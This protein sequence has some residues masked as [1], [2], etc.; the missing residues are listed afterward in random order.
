[1]ETGANIALC[2]RCGAENPARA[3][4]CSRCW[5]LLHGPTCP[6]C[7][8]RATR[9]GARFCEHCGLDLFTESSSAA[10]VAQASVP[11]TTVPSTLIRQEVQSP[12]TDS[13]LL[14]EP[15][16][17]AEVLEAAS[18]G[19][20]HVESPEASLV[21]PLQPSVEIEVPVHQAPGPVHAGPPPALASRPPVAAPPVA[22]PPVAAP[23]AA[24]PTTEEQPVAAP[25]PPAHAIDPD[26]FVIM[27]DPSADLVLRPRIWPRV[28]AGVAALVVA[29]AIFSA[30]RR[31]DTEG[32]K[33]AAVP[34]P[35]PT[36]TNVEQPAAASPQPPAG[37]SAAPRQPA[38]SVGI[39]KITTLPS[40]AQV[41]LDG[42]T[43]GVT[44]VTL[45]DV[46][47]GKHSL[48]VS[49]T[50]FKAVSRD[51]D[52][53]AGESV[54]LDLTLPPAPTPTP[55]RR[56]PAARPLPPPPPPPPP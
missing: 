1:M 17:P 19:S 18:A 7:G 53:A 33:R 27:S 13:A 45:M 54:T 36:A 12:A 44:D 14:V 43:V 42:T 20:V 16:A 35:R 21:E 31:P 55:R 10:P 41:E 38:Q 15:G 2:P 56:G 39:L 9:A 3:R 6:H 49:K 32:A 26:K 37:L 11:P 51:L 22:A 8:K 40:G 30:T 23:S 47:P 24:E 52:V 29:I 4:S 28:A 34:S 25:A 46:T 48:K 50:G 5:G